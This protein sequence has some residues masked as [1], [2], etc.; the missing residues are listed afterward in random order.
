MRIHKR[1]ACL[2]G[3]FCAYGNVDCFG[4]CQH[5]LLYV[6]CTSCFFFFFF[7]FWEFLWFN[8][9]PIEILS[10]SMH[11]IATSNY[12]RIIAISLRVLK[13]PLSVSGFKT[14]EICWC[15]SWR[16]DWEI[17][18]S[19]GVRHR[20]QESTQE[21]VCDLRYSDEESRNIIQLSWLLQFISTLSWVPSLEWTF[22]EQF[23][24][25]W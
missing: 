19:G 13:P 24:V 3:R 12:C 7:F 6:C 11:D 1:S 4:M 16:G 17:L 18:P 9:T 23:H 10:V 15:G 14:K 2:R 8:W 5:T 22:V 20:C 25:F 21:W